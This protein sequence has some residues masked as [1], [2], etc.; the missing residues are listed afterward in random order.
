MIL[1]C[2]RWFAGIPA[3]LGMP[4]G[5]AMAAAIP[6]DIAQYY[7]YMLQAAQKEMYP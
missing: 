3:A 4:G 2:D 6:A 5:V 1:A 7:G